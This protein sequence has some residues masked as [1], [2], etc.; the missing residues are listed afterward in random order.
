[1]SIEMTL[2]YLLEKA[3]GFVGTLGMFLNFFSKPWTCICR[4]L[5]QVTFLFLKSYLFSMLLL[6][7][8]L[9]HK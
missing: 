6:L 7:L 5:I 9:L 8:L 4:H 2:I 3:T 1:M